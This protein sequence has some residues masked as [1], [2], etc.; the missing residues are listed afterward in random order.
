MKKIMIII[1]LICGI[2]CHVHAQWNTTYGVN[3]AESHGA[4]TIAILVI[5]AGYFAYSATR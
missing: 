4:P 1:T 2:V 5:R 3:T